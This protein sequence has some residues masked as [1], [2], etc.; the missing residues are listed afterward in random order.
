MHSVRHCTPGPLDYGFLLSALQSE[1]YPPDTI[2]IACPSM[3]R[4]VGERVLGFGPTSGSLPPKQSV[5][6][7]K[8]RATS[9]GRRRRRTECGDQETD[10]PPLARGSA[11]TRGEGHGT[12]QAI[13][14]LLKPV[15]N[16][17]RRESARHA[18]PRDGYTGPSP[19]PG[20][21]GSRG[22]PLRDPPA[23]GGQRHR[24]IHRGVASGVEKQE[25]AG[26]EPKRVSCRRRGT[27][28]GAVEE[29]VDY[30]VDLAE[31]PKRRRGEIAGE[32]AVS[33]RQ[34]REAAVGLQD[35]IEG[36]APVENL[37][38]DGVGA[39]ARREAGF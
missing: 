12:R 1:S 38:Q 22:A 16:C 8:L 6:T 19:E 24:R 33:V 3:L 18:P 26:A 20:G 7:S 29:A 27:R 11:A 30:R 37:V 31:T 36:P 15:R 32:G 14:A 4:E 13:G 2:R 25:L 34:P 23:S 10:A 5:G 39:L 35:L 9:H 17:A 28:Q 21:A